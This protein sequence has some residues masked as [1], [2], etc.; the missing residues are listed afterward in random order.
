MAIAGL[1]FASASRAH[2]ANILFDL[3]QP[4]WIAG[5]VVRFE[6]VNPHTRFELDVREGAAV[7]R[8]TVE[9]PFLAR[10]KR[11]GV[12]E[13][14]LKPG[15]VIQVCG[16]PLKDAA[17]LRSSSSESR[18]RRRF[19]HGHVLVFPNG[20]LRAWGPYGKIDNCVRPGDQPRVWTDLLNADPLA[21]DAW[22]DQTR[23]VIATRA[24]SKALVTAIGRSMA[25][26]CSGS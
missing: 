2:H 14:V 1:A 11:M 16:F 5:T 8:W 7:H 19:V 26:P 3:S 20:Q 15:D 21:R 22:C 9:G 4:I 23:A 17:A 18:E 10:L 12:D 25:K 6:L 24:D 13:Q